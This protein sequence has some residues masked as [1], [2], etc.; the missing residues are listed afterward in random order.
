[1]ASIERAARKQRHNYG[2]DLRNNCRNERDEGLIASI[3][4]EQVENKKNR[5]L[6]TSAIARKYQPQIPIESMK[7]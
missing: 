5:P 4:T 7:C 2:G 6:F 1:M 3:C